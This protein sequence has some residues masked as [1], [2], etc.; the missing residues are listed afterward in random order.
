MIKQVSSINSYNKIGL[1][2]HSIMYEIQKVGPL[3]YLL[4]FQI[5]REQKRYDNTS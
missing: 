1:N 4:S 3:I 5:H 2:L